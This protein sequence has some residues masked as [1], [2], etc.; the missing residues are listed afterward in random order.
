MLRLGSL[1]SA[2][3]PL[4]NSEKVRQKMVMEMITVQDGGYGHTTGQHWSSRGIFR[5]SPGLQVGVTGEEQCLRIFDEA[6]VLSR[7]WSTL[8]SPSS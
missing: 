7:D 2:P 3:S 1:L 5:E 8:L 6:F 4:R